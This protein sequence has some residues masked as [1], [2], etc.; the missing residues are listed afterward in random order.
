MRG[1]TGTIRFSLVPV[2]GRRAALEVRLITTADALRETDPRSFLNWLH[3]SGA[4]AGEAASVASAARRTMGRVRRA[5]V[6]L[7]GGRDRRSSRL[8][9]RKAVSNAAS[10]KTSAPATGRTGRLG[11]A[12]AMRPM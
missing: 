2:R 3:G 5:P 12:I 8:T 4:C 10:P 1:S 6:L 9:T 7:L 11:P